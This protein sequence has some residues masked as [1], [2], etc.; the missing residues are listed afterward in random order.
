MSQDID[1]ASVLA[2]LEKRKD[3][4]ET[5]ILAIKRIL[6]ENTEGTG[7]P[8]LAGPPTSAQPSLPSTIEPGIFHT[9]SVSETA[10]RYLEI[11]KKKQTTREICDAILKG[12]IETS[13]KSFYVNV[14]TTLQ[15]RKDFIKLGKEWALAEWHPARAASQAQ[16][17]TK[18]K[19]KRRSKRKTVKRKAVAKPRAVAPIS[20]ASV[21]SEAG[22]G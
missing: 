19:K 18:R 14:Y 11:V 20:T 21:S 12:G 3:A 22:E 2:D 5:A 1:Y 10:K 6:G 13:A 16:V 9:L 17:K 15:R 4:L 7:L 8:E